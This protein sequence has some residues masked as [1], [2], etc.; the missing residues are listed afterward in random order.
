MIR[1]DGVTKRYGK[2]AAVDDLTLHVPPGE[3]FGFIGPNGAGKTTTMKMIAGLLYPTSGRILVDGIDIQQ[4]PI[5][6]KRVLGYIPDRPYLYEKL[7]GGEFLVFVAELF[8]LARPEADRR[9]P[10]LLA[11]FAL[12]DWGDELIDAYSHGMKQRLVMAAAFLHRP[13]AIIVDEPMV[14]LDPKGARLVKRLFARLCTE[15][16][17]TVFLST[18]TLTVAEEICSRIAILHHGKIVAQGDL[19]ALRE[20]ARVEGGDLE[21]VF[22]SL[23][24]EVEALDAEQLEV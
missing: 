3:I 13:K 23:T 1:L 12:N 22:L 6:A 9:I 19:N 20:R 15:R 10:D 14:G 18:H 21:A 7:T 11:A 4:D 16:N 8:G 24:E 5:G 2:L 17:V